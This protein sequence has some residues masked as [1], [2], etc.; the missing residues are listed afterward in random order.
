MGLE[1]PELIP[2]AN[3]HTFQQKS[4]NEINAGSQ[5]PV[6]PKICYSDD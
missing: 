5:T 1:F 6:S 2:T 4:S 3:V